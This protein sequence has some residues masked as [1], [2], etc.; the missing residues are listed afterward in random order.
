VCGLIF[1]PASE[2]ISREEEKKR[3]NLHDN[4][5]YNEGY[6]NY[7]NEIVGIVCAKCSPSDRI[8]DYGSGK[9]VVLTR[10]LQDNCKNNLYFK[11]AIFI[12]P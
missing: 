5:A 6:V 11:I 12:V 4:S 3:Y 10:L 2:H 9:N 8:L 7:L 1:V